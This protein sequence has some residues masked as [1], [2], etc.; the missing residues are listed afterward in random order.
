V[1]RSRQFQG[2]RL[3]LYQVI[4]GAGLEVIEKLWDMLEHNLTFGA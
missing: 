1:H 2:I 3:L 4:S